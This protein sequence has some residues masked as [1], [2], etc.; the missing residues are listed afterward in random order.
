MQAVLFFAMGLL[1]V[2]T[3]AP[4]RPVITFEAEVE[5]PDAMLDN[6]M[7]R[8]RVV[9]R[10]HAQ[11]DDAPRSAELFARLEAEHSDPEPQ[12][13]ADNTPWVTARV[14]GPATG[15][16]GAA[17]TVEAGRSAP[18]LV[19]GNLASTDVIALDAAGRAE[20]TL[21]LE[22]ATTADAITTRVRWTTVHLTARV[23]SDEDDRRELPW[24]VEV[25]AEVL[26]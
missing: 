1:L 21:E 25:I 15:A 22:R 11:R 17:G 26:P 6:A 7:P 12:R 13:R 5:I 10:V 20:L 18:F 23:P 14:V 4:P 24:D 19:D 8:Q 16:A 9:L 3:S 2:A